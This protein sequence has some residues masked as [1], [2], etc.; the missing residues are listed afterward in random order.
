MIWNELKMFVR[1]RFFKNY[2]EV[3]PS[4]AEFKQNF[5]EAKFKYIN[6]LHTVI[7]IVI[8]KKGDWSDN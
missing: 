1:S 8:N 6:H 2:E 3:R 4:I 7:L 5:T